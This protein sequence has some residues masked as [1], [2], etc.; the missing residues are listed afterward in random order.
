[1]TY[2][3]KGLFYDEVDNYINLI[4]VLLQGLSFGQRLRYL[5]MSNKDGEISLLIAMHQG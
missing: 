1:M 2:L 4:K 5:H 3:F